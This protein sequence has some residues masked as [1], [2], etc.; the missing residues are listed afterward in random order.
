MTETADAIIAA[1]GLHAHPEGGFF[2]ETWRDPHPPGAR[3]HST[4]IYYLLRAGD[5]S[6][7]H[8][9]DAVEVWHYYAGAPLDLR[10]SPDGTRVERARLG[11]SIARGERPQ[12]VVPVRCWQSARSGGEWTLARVHGR[13][14]I[15]VR[16]VRAR[17]TGLGARSAVIADGAAPVGRYRVAALLR[18]VARGKV[19]Q[20]DREG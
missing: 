20:D 17:G 7:W 1:L 12:V 19:S 10:L 18:G 14:G 5:D 9:I 15:R 13:P 11:P 2:A 8:R 6:R 4:A 3:G 16:R